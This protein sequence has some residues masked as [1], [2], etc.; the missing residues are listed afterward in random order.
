MAIDQNFLLGEILELNTAITQIGGKI[1][2]FLQEQNAQQAE[3]E[4]IRL[5]ICPTSNVMLGLVES[6]A[7][8]PIRRLYDAGVVV[9]INTDEVLVFGQG[10]SE[11]FLALFDT[12]LFDARELDG[13]SLNGLLDD[14]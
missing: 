10:V 5:T 1:D 2:G 13:I 3:I 8:H 6:L 14:D 11:E 4:C 9:T 7:S 12:G